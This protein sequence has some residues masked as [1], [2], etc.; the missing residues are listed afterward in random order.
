MMQPLRLIGRDLLRVP[1]ARAQDHLA[2]FSRTVPIELQRTFRVIGVGVHDHA[3]FRAEVQKPQHVAPESAAITSSSGLYRS[4]FPRNAGA[5][6][7]GMASTFS[8]PV[9]SCS[10]P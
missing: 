9:I 8:A 6:D 1:H 10:R 3:G 7:A 2:K 5:E 4:L